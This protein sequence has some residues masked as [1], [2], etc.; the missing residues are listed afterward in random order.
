MFELEHVFSFLFL[1]QFSELRGCPN[2]TATR[3][4]LRPA[5]CFVLASLAKKLCHLFVKGSNPPLLGDG[6]GRFPSRRGHFSGGRGRL[7]GTPAPGAA[8]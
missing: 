1:E 5:P 7:P 4:I 3:C 6:P 2:S 8:P